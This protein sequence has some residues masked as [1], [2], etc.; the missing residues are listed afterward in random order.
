[1]RALPTL[2]F[3]ILSSACTTANPLVGG[4]KIEDAKGVK[5][6][7]RKELV[8]EEKTASDA[9]RAKELL[10]KVAQDYE[11][12]PWATRASWEIKRGFGS[13]IVPYYFDT[14]LRKP[15]KMEV[16]IPKL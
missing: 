12:T 16:P 11:G 3:V 1:M 8:A 5:H 4:D 13:S 7:W 14:R 2:A 6:D 10:S 9:E 15:G